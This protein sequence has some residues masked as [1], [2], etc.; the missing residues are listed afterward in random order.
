MQSE[1]QKILI[2]GTNSGLGKWL[3]TQLAHCDKFTRNDKISDFE[4]HTYDLIIHCAATVTHCGWKNAPYSLFEDNVFLTRELVKIP[5][6]KFILISSI[7]QIK[8]SPYGVS[9]RLAEIVVRDFCDKYLILRPSALLGKEMRKNSF[10]KILSNEDIPLT[11]Q[12]IMNYI[13]YEDVLDAI[14]SGG[15]GTKFLRANKDITLL[16]VVEALNKKVN[17]GSIHFEVESVESD[18]DTKK[19]SRDNVLIFGEKC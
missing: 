5:H 19:T 12:T 1:L 13:L 10:Q 8:N 2:T 16:E 4:Q 14:K 18:I 7:D 15:E 6:K 3:S 11:P 9:K 17:F